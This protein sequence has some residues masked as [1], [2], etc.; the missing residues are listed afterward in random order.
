MRVLVMAAGWSLVLMAVAFRAGLWGL[1]PLPRWLPQSLGLLPALAGAL[2]IAVAWPM[3]PLAALGS[4]L[5]GGA[6]TLALGCLVVRDPTRSLG[7]L[8]LEGHE[9]GEPVLL[10]PCARAWTGRVVVLAHGGGNDRLFG[11]SYLVETLLSRGHAVLTAHLPGHGRRGSDLFTVAASRAR[12]DALVGQAHE[13]DGTSR[14]VLV[15]QSL[16]GSLALDLGARGGGVDG[17]IALSAPAELRVGPWVVRELR[18]LVRPCIY[19]ALRYGN[20][21]ESLP[22]AGRFKRGSFPV[23]VSNGRPYLEAFSDAVREL[24]LLERL[25]RCR[26]PVCSVLLVHGLDDA[27]VP[28]GQALALAQALGTRCE[29]GLF[30]R[31]SHLDLLYDRRVV[32]RVA[33]WIEQI[34]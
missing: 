26:S 10:R 3:S 7:A 14:V 17:I 29:L 18:A 22:A 11:C 30:A 6:V 8:P 32:E 34:V 21:C 15:G 27:V 24:D 33:E 5:L 23:R 16:G 28:P 2:L 1:H 25:G 20:L 13:L 9:D 31:V 12:L 4:P 19:R